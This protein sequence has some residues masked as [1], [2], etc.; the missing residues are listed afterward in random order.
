MEPGGIQRWPTGRRL[1]DPTLP[2]RQDLDHGRRRGVR[3]APRLVASQLVN[4]TAYRFRVAA[5]NGAGQG[6]WSATVRATPRWIPAAPGRLVA[7]VAPVS[8]CR[9]ATG[10]AD[11]EPAG[12]QPRAAR[13]TDYAIQRSLDGRTWT[14][15]HDGVSAQRR[16]LV[17][18]LTNGTRYRFRVAA[19]NGVGQGPWSATVRAT[20]RWKP[21]APIQLGAVVGHRRV[22]LTWSRRR[23]TAGLGLPT[24]SSSPPA[25]DGPGRR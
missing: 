25:P 24:T 2:R 15:V 14:T 9:P 4:G 21:T 10:Q 16:A 23:P 1:R 12:S 5:V 22:T 8:R 3:P 7:A 17:S 18:R 11:L 6:P 20:P 13:I 19:V